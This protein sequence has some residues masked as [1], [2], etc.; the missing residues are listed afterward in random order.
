MNNYYLL[1]WYKNLLILINYHLIMLVF[2]DIFKNDEFMSDI[3]KFELAYEDAIMKVQSTY[4]N[5]DQVGNINIGCGNAFG[6]GEEEDAGNGNTGNG[7]K[8]IDVI[9]NANLQLFTMSKSEFMAYIKEY[10][11]RIVKYL[12]ENG[13]AD[14]IPGFKKG[15]SAFIKFIVPKFDE[16]EIYCGASK[17]EDDDLSGSIAISYWEDESAAGPMIFFFNDALKEVKC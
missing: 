17:T 10:F 14:R 2:Q 4:K 16:I 1:N 9:H 11:G 13:K 3:F 12:E 6:A 5:P 7:V 8:V 15:A